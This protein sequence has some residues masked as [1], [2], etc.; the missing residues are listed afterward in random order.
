MLAKEGQ[1]PDSRRAELDL[2]RNELEVERLQL[3]VEIEKQTLADRAKI[4]KLRELE[5]AE[6]EIEVE[7]ARL[8][9]KKEQA[10]VRGDW[11][12]EEATGDNASS[13]S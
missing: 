6:R 2:K 13:G 11:L 10:A 12:A 8:Q 1:V 3:Q 5:V 9:L 7:R 4:Q